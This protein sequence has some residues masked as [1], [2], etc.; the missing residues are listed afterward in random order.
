MI[1]VSG[2]ACAADSSSLAAAQV[3]Q[4]DASL[5]GQSLTLPPTWLQFRV[6]NLIPKEGVKYEIRVVERMRLE[7]ELDLKSFLGGSK[8]D[9][10]DCTAKSNAIRAK[11]LDA[12]S[13]KAVK[14][15]LV[16]APADLTKAGCSQSAQK[17]HVD[18]LRAVTSFEVMNVFPLEAGREISV[19]V[20]R[21][22]A[23]VSTYNFYTPGS[24]WLISYGFTFVQNKDDD[25]FSTAVG[26][27]AGAFAITKGRS[28]DGY[29]FAPSIFFSRRTDD[30]KEHAWCL[31]CRIVPA[32]GVGTDFENVSVFLGLGLLYGDNI[33]V[34]LGGAVTQ[35]AELRGKYR[36][37]QIIQE[38]LDEDQ[39]TEKKWGGTV[40][41]GLTFRFNADTLSALRGKKNS[42]GAE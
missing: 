29:D 12:A 1:F 9:V 30:Q 23:V 39:L 4:I 21:D 10:D 37:G 19:Q 16:A 7:P 34:T 11:L 20:V 40:Y 15:T 25:Y 38:E 41:F 24:E 22:G 3:Q 13:E 28:S 14:D 36:N 5:N 33:M 2:A 31:D 27:P 8:G 18:S 17:A 6:V 42:S 32:F 35:Q 26:D